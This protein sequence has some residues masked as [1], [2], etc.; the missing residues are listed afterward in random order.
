VLQGVVSGT[1]AALPNRLFGGMG[2]DPFRLHR[3]DLIRH[4]LPERAHFVD[5]NRATPKDGLR[6]LR[7]ASC[8]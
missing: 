1:A 4:K 8:S 5:G 6:G 2:D 7:G 3:Q